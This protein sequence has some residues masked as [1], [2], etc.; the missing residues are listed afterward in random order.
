MPPILSPP[1]A[2]DVERRVRRGRALV[3]AHAATPSGGGSKSGATL[4][5]RSQWPSHRLRVV[6]GC[7]APAEWSGRNAAPSSAHV[8]GRAVLVDVP[9]MDPQLRSITRRNFLTA[10]ALIGVGAVGGQALEFLVSAGSPFAPAP[11][12]SG[13]GS[14]PA[15]TALALAAAS[16]SPSVRVGAASPGTSASAVPSLA[17]DQGRWHYRSRPDLKPPIV[18]AAVE[19]AGA[20]PGYIL[21]TPGNGAG[22]DGPVIIDAEGD[23][24]WI[25]PGT[26]KASANLSVARF[27][28]RP[29]ITWWEG[30]LNGG[31]GDGEF[32][33]ADETYRELQR[34]R[35]GNGYR[36]DLHEFQITPHGTALLVA[37]NFTSGSAPNGGP[38]LPWEIV[39]DVVQEIDLRTG[40][41]VFEWHSA[42]DIDPSES[43]V[44]PPVKSGDIYDYVHTNSIDID[45]DGNFLVSAR[46]T[47]ALY[48]I[49]RTTGKLMWRLGGKRSDF[50]LGDGASFGYQHDARSRHDGTITLFDDESSPGTSR[51]ITLR[52]DETAR[53]VTLVQAFARPDALL[54]RS[55]GSMQVLANGNVFV[56]W[57]SQPFFTEFAP[58]GS[59]VF[60][61]SFVAGGQSYRSL[62]QAWVGRPTEPPAVAASAGSA[63]DGTHVFASWNGAT[64]VA[65]WQVLGGPSASSLAPL[66]TAPRLAFETAIRVKG[67]PAYVAVKAFD[68]SG[69]EL[70]T[71]PAVRVQ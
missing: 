28:G 22:V 18:E 17:P 59:V 2:V 34:V 50:V 41:V 58:D 9:D 55:Q 61:A 13:A 45:T 35:A 20:E 60:D 63:S 64:D 49:S 10:A 25:R 3:V 62:R 5:E 32:V 67:A 24:V 48:K 66:V 29:V 1:R 23:P 30:T 7:A 44:A 33:I 8:P 42:A 65:A 47:S 12:R 4:S 6:R 19:A 36:T 57:G 37:G 68:G 71:S 53:T 52:V 16:A 69:E 15:P 14:S 40:K 27:G 51:A 11:G 21:Y 70:A 43:L 56:G 54:A 26:G 39:D 38:G 31:N 46:N